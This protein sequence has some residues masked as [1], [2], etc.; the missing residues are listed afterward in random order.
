MM[1]I[2]NES[3]PVVLRC[4]RAFY[5]SFVPQLWVW[6]WMPVIL[7]VGIANGSG[8]QIATGAFGTALSVV[9]YGATRARYRPRVL[10]DAEMVYLPRTNRKPVQIPIAD[11]AWIGLVKTRN[12][13]PM[14]YYGGW[15]TWMTTVD[16][17]ALCP[18]SAYYPKPTRP[19]GGKGAEAFAV[20]VRA[21]PQGQFA[22]ELW[23]RVHELQGPAGALTTGEPRSLPAGR[24]AVWSAAP[25]S[26]VMRAS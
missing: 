20:T 22:S 8:V 10:L 4:H 7:I 1:P 25:G 21:S 16:G 18:I 5:R 24:D 9:V 12:V 3:G 15:R 2:M 23:S 19:K 11:V 6:C 17:Q 26:H 14:G 13:D